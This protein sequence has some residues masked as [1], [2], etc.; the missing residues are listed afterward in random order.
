LIVELIEGV[1]LLLALCFLQNIVLRYTPG[2]ARVRDVA[3]GLLFGGICVFGMVTPIEPVHGVIFDARSVVLAM[4]GLFGGPVVG[5]I[6]GV[7]AGGYRLWLGGGGAGVGVGVMVISVA[8]GLAYRHLR[9]RHGV[10]TGLVQFV[11]FGVVVHAATVSWFLLLP[12]EVVEKVMTNVVPPFVATFIPATALLGLLLKDVEKRMETERELVRSRERFRSLYQ[13]TPVLMHSVDSD[14]RLLDVNDSWLARLGYTRDEVIGKPIVDLMT[15]ESRAHAGEVIPR[16]F[17]EGQI[18]DEPYQFIAKNGGVVDVLLSATAEFDDHGRFVRSRAVSDD[19]TEKLANERALK[20]SEAALRQAQK[21]EALGQLTGGVAHDFNN[22]LAI[23]LGNV[24]LMQRKYADDPV[25]K[26]HLEPIERSVL[27]G[28]GLTQRLL[29]FARNQ[30]LTPKPIHIGDLLMGLDDMLRR[31][32]GE[33][34]AVDL[35]VADDLWP[36]QA[37]PH[38]LEHSLVNLAVNAR[39]AMPGG[40]SLTVRVENLPASALPDAVRNDVTNGDYVRICVRDSG[41]G[42]DAETLER[43]FEP[44]FTTKA[45]GHGSGLGLSMVYGFAKQSG[46]HVTAESTPGKGAAISIYLPRSKA[47]PAE[48]RPPC[49]AA[50][51]SS[52]GERILIVEDDPEVRQV[53][54]QM[55]ADAGYRFAEA[56]D[57]EQALALL[58]EQGPFDLLFTDVVLAGAID[59]VSLARA[60]RDVQPGLPVVFATGYSPRRIDALS[61]DP[62]EELSV[63]NKPYAR[64]TLQTTLRSALEAA[65]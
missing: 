32:L 61:G 5:V 7:I 48:A 1:A 9:L 41:A 25:A 56:G 33:R 57:G 2:G 65:A 53:A 47:L 27:R 51:Q 22:L 54:A 60:A 15:P 37:D 58:R 23:M 52:G 62:G 8:L 16:F 11:I 29:A 59:G 4:A 19:V 21:M 24:Q 42:M 43:A 26:E 34:V 12:P 64:D 6:A 17:R 31:T 39:D 30:P 49:A 50:A 40:G 46:G 38:Q 20:A 36:V 13:Q 14:A 28:A 44:F 18:S 63:I 35:A 55:L 3:S 45:M 10:G